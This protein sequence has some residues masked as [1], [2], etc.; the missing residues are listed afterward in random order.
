MTTHHDQRPSPFADRRVPPITT[1]LRDVAAR[2]VAAVPAAA[3]CG[4]TLMTTDGRRITSVATD[5][6]GD[7]VLGLHDR[8]RDNPGTSVWLSGNVIRLDGASVA[9][10]HELWAEHVGRLGV[11]SVLAAALSTADR[12]LGTVMLYSLHDDAFCEVDEGTL[13]SCAHEAATLVDDGLT[14]RATA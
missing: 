7:G 9:G 13:S 6:I 10:R 3:G 5:L 2:C 12:M 14:L 4:V 11:R 8:C 1:T